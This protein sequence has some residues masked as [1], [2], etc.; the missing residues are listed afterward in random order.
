MSFL[1][2][3]HTKAQLRREKQAASEA[4]EAIDFEA[5]RATMNARRAERQS[6]FENLIGAIEV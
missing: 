3:F 2:P 6:N 5:L 1:P 4:P